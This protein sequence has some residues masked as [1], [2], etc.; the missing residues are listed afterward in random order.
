[1]DERITQ[2]HRDVLARADAIAKR[3][4]VDYGGHEYEGLIRQLAL[5]VVQQ[6]EAIVAVVTALDPVFDFGDYEDDCIDIALDVATR[7]M[8]GHSVMLCGCAGDT[9]VCEAGNPSACQRRLKAVAV[10]ER[11]KTVRRS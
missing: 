7:T 4:I 10:L 1:M 8:A 2:A 9:T 5:L 3:E 11:A 6:H